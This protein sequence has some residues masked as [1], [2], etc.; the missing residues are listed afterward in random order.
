MNVRP[1][2]D[3]IVIKIDP[4]S[5]KTVSGL[6]Y[7]PADAYEHTFATAEVLAV[8]PGKWIKDTDKKTPMH[9]EKGDG[10]IFVLFLKET[11]S[12]KAIQHTLGKD[13]LIIHPNDVCLVYDRNNPPEVSQ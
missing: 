13:V 7:K 8:G 11:A 6:L 1:L 2:N 4:Q 12:N 5:E 3:S 9:I 10:V